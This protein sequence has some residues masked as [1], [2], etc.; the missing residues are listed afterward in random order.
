MTKNAITS[1]L[2]FQIMV[3]A[4]NLLTLGCTLCPAFLIA[5]PSAMQWSIKVAQISSE[6]TGLCSLL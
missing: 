4:V 3:D 2:N 5:V 1:S 6:I